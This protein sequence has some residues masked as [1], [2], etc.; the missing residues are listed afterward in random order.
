MIARVTLTLAAVLLLGCLIECFATETGQAADNSAMER[1]GD[2]RLART[3]SHPAEPISQQEA[4]KHASRTSSLRFEPL[5][6]FLL[7]SILFS[8]S[9]TIKLVLSRK[10]HRPMQ[11]LATNESPSPKFRGLSPSRR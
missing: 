8:L 10:L 2:P 6:L 5:M 3:D 4:S 9:T 7:G 1:D 11:R